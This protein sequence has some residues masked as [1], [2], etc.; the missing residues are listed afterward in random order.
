MNENKAEL[1]KNINGV[2]IYPTSF[3]PEKGRMEDSRI[4]TTEMSGFQIEAIHVVIFI[5]L[6]YALFSGAW[7]KAGK[8]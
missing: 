7:K 4:P 5:L 2:K 1:T 3:I 6:T 8:R